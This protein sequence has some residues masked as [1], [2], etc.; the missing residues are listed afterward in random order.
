M[1][2]AFVS[3]LS[4]LAAVSVA[5]AAHAEMFNGPTVGVQAGWVENKVGDT[6]TNFGATAV[7]G[8]KDSATLGGLFGY[9]KQFGKFVVGGEAGFNFGTSDKVAGGTGTTQATIDPKRSFDLTTR[10]GYLVLP[11]TLLYARAGYTND[12]VQ[13]TLTPSSGT[14][15]ASEDRDGWLVGGGIERAITSDVSAR[16]EYRYGDLSDGHGRYDRHQV[17]SGV[18]FHF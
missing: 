2:I 5:S 1:K 17:L 18:V 8:S 6:T 3:V 15:S 4:L 16:V 11:Q 12:R 7:N 10:T 9:D 14:V 13:T